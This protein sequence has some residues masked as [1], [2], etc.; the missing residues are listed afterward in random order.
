MPPVEEENRPDE[1]VMEEARSLVCEFCD[2]EEMPSATADAL[3][4][5][6]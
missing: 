5:R 3:S 4:M 2:A 6:G 1:N